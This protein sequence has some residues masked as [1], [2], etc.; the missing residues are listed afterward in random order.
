MPH[1]YSTV[2]ILAAALCIALVRGSAVADPPGEPPSYKSPVELA[3]S[4]DGAF[5]Y[6]TNQ[7]AGSL[8]VVDT[9]AA[10]VVKEIPLGRMPTGV[11]VSPDG[12]TVFAANTLDHQISFVEVQSGQVVAE[13]ACGFEPTGLCISPD[14][15]TL[16]S[17]NYISDDLSVID[18]LQRKEIARIPVE[19]APTYPAITP[20]GKTLLVQNSLSSRPATDTK[21]SAHVSVIDTASRKITASRRSPGTMLLGMG[22]AMHPSGSHAFAVHHRPNFN[23]TPSQLSQGWV[24]TNALS[25]IPL[26]NPEGEVITV[27][28]DNVNSGAA[29]PHG[30]AV[31]PDGNTL[32]VTNRGIHRIS[33][34]DLV[35]LRALLAATPPEKR[36]GAHFNLGYLWGAKGIIRRVDCGGLGPKGI[37]VSP[38]DGTVYVANYF[39]DSV[40]VLNP[41]TLEVTHRIALGPPLEMTTERRG[42]LF[43]NDARQCFQQWLSCTSCHPRVRADGVNWDLLNDGMTNPKNA[44]SLVGAWQTPPSMSLGVRARMEVAVSKGF[45]FIQF[46]QPADDEVEA[47][48]A[49]L[50]SVEFIPSPWHR[51]ADGSLDALA[52]RGQRVFEIAQCDMCH[53]EPLYTDLEMYN[54][55]TQGPR[56]F[57]EHKRFDVPTLKEAYRTAPFLHDGR[58]AT[59]REVLTTYNPEDRHGKTSRLSPEDIDAL[60]AFLKTL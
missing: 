46:H 55:G 3:V 29:N 32:Y 19:R 23:I 39:S 44:K 52:Q 4:P 10:A 47:V 26:A 33:V 16:Y 17:A 11:A 40:A 49:Y 1:P 34:V 5:L 54:V 22:M 6:V 35:K 15:T 60:I 2:S 27:Q 42:E 41:K 25:I 21:L 38:R 30:V 48:S 8:S 24:Q 53:P 14:G 13:V 51:Q 58:A 28:L 31:S 7:T 37:A 18:V 43:F 57:P 36:S 20:N 59:L 9:R 12:K 56:D 45:L 50:R